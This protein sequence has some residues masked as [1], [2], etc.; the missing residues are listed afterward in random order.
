MNTLLLYHNTKNKLISQSFSL[1]EGPNNCIVAYTEKLSS[2]KELVFDNVILFGIYFK[3][4]SEKDKNCLN[5]NKLCS[6]KT[7]LWNN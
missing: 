7:V 1:P 3:D 4:L 6:I 2:I 5:L